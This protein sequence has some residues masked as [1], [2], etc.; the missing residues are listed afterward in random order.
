MI[1]FGGWALPVQYTGILE[2]HQCV[3][4]RVGIFDVSHMG[5]VL[6]RGRGAFAFVQKLITNDISR[7]TDGKVL[8]SPMCY[9]EGGVVDDILVYRM[10][11]ETY[12]LVVNASNTDKDFEWMKDNLS[13]GA[14]LTNI[15]QDIAQ[16][17][18]Q[19]PN[20]EL[21]MKKLLGLS[22]LHM[23][24]FSF[25]KG[26]NIAGIECMVSRTGYTGEDGFEL[27]CPAESGAKLWECIMEAGREYGLQPA[28]LGARDTLRFEACMPLYGNE[29]S[30]DI[31]PIE[32]GLGNFVK[33]NKEYFIGKEALQAMLD[34][35]IHRI[36]VGF[37]ML[38]RGIPRSHY[39][40]V[41]GG[42]EIGF[43]TSGS[44][45]PTLKKNLG[46]AIISTEYAE[47]GRE[48]GI[49]IRGKVLKAAV[50]DMPFYKRSKAK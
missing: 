8:Y 37:E 45:S 21:I 28:G 13:D 9:P 35:G 38:D 10:D 15:S 12:L 48:I 42:E 11:E 16:I 23:R 47:K 20:S 30:P 14:E 17:A 46:M 6:V 32:A 22:E 49:E 18:L 50:V 36:R 26:M 41:A 2:E 27:Y 19:G 29:L 24:Y 34:K 25:Q 4:E 43:V 44:F 40:V 7:M 3:R 31:T 5:E 1:D 33:M 39:K